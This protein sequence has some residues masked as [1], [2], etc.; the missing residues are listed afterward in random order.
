MWLIGLFAIALA[1]GCGSVNVQAAVVRSQEFTAADVRR[2]S[3]T[4][5][6]A[7]WDLKH[8]HLSVRVIPETKRLEGSNK[9]TFQTV[10]GGQQMQIDLQ[11]PLTISRVVH[12]DRELMFTRHGNYYL[13][14]FFEPLPAGVVTEIE[15]FYQ[16]RPVE[17]K[18]PPWSGGITWTKD[19]KGRPFIASSCQGIGASVWWP[20]KDHGADEPD[21]GVMISVTVPEQLTAVA[22]GRLLGTESDPVNAVRTFHWRVTHPINNY[23]VNINVG[24]YV[25]FSERYDGAYGALDMQH[26]VL[27]HQRDRAMQHFK[28]APRVMAAFEYWFGKYPFYED[29]YKLVAVPYLGMEHQ[30]SVTYGNGFKNG[31]QGRDLSG[32][33]VGLLFDFIIVHESGHEWFGNN[34][35]MNDTADMWIH[36]SFTNYSESLFVEYHFGKRQ[37]EDYV[38]GLR[39]LIKNDRPIVGTY[40]VNHSGSGDMYYK[41]ANMLHSLRQMVNDRDR[42]RKTL[43]GL[44][45]EFRYQMVS[46]KQVED[47]LSEHTGMDLSAFFDQYLRTTKVPVFVFETRGNQLIFHYDNVV[48]GFDFPLVIQVNGQPYRIFPREDRQIVRF[49][50]LIDS[51]EVDRNFYV[52]T[53][54]H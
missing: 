35:S 17:A 18:N 43:T 16:G 5:E 23:C 20:C 2:G 51:C 26:W 4:P 8:Y 13:V 24:R 14:S 32:T 52:E 28:E 41:G 39:K 33:G 45:D 47:Y 27:D 12:G 30:S 21:D 31:Y 22:N 46:S 37:A 53:R 29:S 48:A 3:I 6:R 50:T 11:Q 36:E 15:I 1:F 38:I 40:G 44:N 49:E 54:R 34:V 9:I 7:W 25:S 42:W 19:S 10:A